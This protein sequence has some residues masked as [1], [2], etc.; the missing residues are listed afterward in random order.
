KEIHKYLH[1]ENFN[2]CI[3]IA[4]PKKLY[5]KI[6]YLILKSKVIV[7]NATMAR[8]INFVKKSNVKLFSYLKITR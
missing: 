7:L 4:K 5:L 1:S 8:F 3:K 2:S 6:I